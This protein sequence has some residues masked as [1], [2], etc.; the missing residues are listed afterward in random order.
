MFDSGFIPTFVCSPFPVGRAEMKIDGFVN[1]L[2]PQA[3]SSSG[4]LKPSTGV[5]SL[6]LID[7]E[8]TH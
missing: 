7:P 1:E 8:I 3:R 6:S 2:L 5:K 4:N